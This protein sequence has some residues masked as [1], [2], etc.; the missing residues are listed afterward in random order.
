LTAAFALAAALIYDPPQDAE[1][2][3]HTLYFIQD[4]QLLGVRDEERFWVIELPLGGGQF[5][6][7]I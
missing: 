3:R 5:Q 7:Q 6:V 4:H 2:A 1:D